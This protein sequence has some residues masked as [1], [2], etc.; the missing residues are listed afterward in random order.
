MKVSYCILYF[1]TLRNFIFFYCQN[2]KDDF[3]ICFAVEAMSL[4]KYGFRS[5]FFHFL[6]VNYITDIANKSIKAYLLTRGAFRFLPFLV[7]HL[8]D[9]IP[10][11]F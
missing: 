11:I 2:K 3:M 10:D 5:V 7:C 1:L 8:E 9:Y 4:M 6:F